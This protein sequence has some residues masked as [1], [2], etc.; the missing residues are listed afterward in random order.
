MSEKQLG[1]EVKIIGLSTEGEI[2][3]SLNLKM[4]TLLKS[5]KDLNKAYQ[6]GLISEKDAI[7]QIKRLMKLK[8]RRRL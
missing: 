7:T 2:L 6:D 3:T 8:H 4:Q 1:F 5:K